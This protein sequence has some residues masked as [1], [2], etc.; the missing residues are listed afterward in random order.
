MKIKLLLIDDVTDYR[1]KTGQG[2]L[3]AVRL[4]LGDGNFS[5][6]KVSEASNSEQALSIASNEKFDIIVLDNDL[7]DGSEK[8]FQ[9][10][11]R[12]RNCQIALG[13]PDCLIFTHSQD[14]Q[15]GCFPGTN[16]QLTPK[17]FVVVGGKFIKKDIKDAL[18]LCIK[19][20]Q[21]KEQE[22][23]AVP[24]MGMHK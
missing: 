20:I 2:L 13:Q 8:G 23:N 21:S 3:E 9:I 1:K 15:L 10:S 4:I 11:Q 16:C 6:E 24:T 14:Y 22:Q 7:G 17:P 5:F 12:I 18:A 19:N